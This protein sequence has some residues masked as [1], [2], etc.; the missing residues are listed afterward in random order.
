MFAHKN[1][2]C[3]VDGLPKRLV[4]KRRASKRSWYFVSATVREV[5][6]DSEQNRKKGRME[7]EPQGVGEKT[8]ATYRGMVRQTANFFFFCVSFLFSCRGSKQIQFGIATIYYVFI[9]LFA[10]LF[11]RKI[12]KVILGFPLGYH[13][14]IE[15]MLER[16]IALGTPSTIS[17][18]SILHYCAGLRSLH[19]GFQ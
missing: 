2:A 9:S 15:L 8:F 10:L 19:I 16:E 18:S 6:S 5:S 11:M 1:N 14:I 17:L 12:Q 7:Q 13:Q 3:A 4:R